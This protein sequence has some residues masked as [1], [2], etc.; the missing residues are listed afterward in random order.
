VIAE[1]RLRAR[2]TNDH[3]TRGAGGLRV[4]VSDGVATLSGV[5]T[6]EMHDAALEIATDTRGVRRVRDTLR[7]RGR[8]SRAP[9]R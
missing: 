6:P 2:L 8:R 1:A 9:R 5:V 3:R 7:E 4:D